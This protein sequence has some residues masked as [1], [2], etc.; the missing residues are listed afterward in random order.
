MSNRVLTAASLLAAFAGSAVAAPEIDALPPNQPLKELREAPRGARIAQQNNSAEQ[1]SL[2]LIYEIAGPTDSGVPGG[3][4]FGSGGSPRT[5]DVG[6]LRAGAGFDVT[7]AVATAFGYGWNTGGSTALPA[8]NFDLVINFFSVPNEG[9]ATSNGSTVAPFYSGQFAS[10]R[11]PDICPDP[12]FVS[13]FPTPIQFLDTNSNVITVT[14]QDSASNP[15]TKFGYEQNYYEVGSSSFFNTRTN[16]FRMGGTLQPRVGTNDFRGWAFG[17]GASGGPGSTP[18]S[19]TATDANTRQLFQREGNGTATNRRDSYLKMWGQLPAP[20]APSVVTDVGTVSCAGGVLPAVTVAFS[21][22]TD[23]M[24]APQGRWFKFTTPVDISSPDL[25]FLDISVD[26]DPGSGIPMQT[27]FG[28]YA[29]NGGRLVADATRGIGAVNPLATFGHG[30]RPGLGGTEQQGRPM[31]RDGRDGAL[32]AGTY[33]LFVTGPEGRYGGASFAVDASESTA[34]GTALLVFDTNA[35][36]TNC[37]LPTPVAPTVTRNLGTLSLGNQATVND[38]LTGVEDVEWYTF[39]TDFDILPSNA[40]FLDIHSIGS[41]LGGNI[42]A[43]Y[44]NSGN[45]VSASYADDDSGGLYLGTNINCA[46]TDTRAQLSFG[47]AAAPRSPLGPGLPFEGQNGDTLAAGTYWLAVGLDNGF[48]LPAGWQVRSDSG[49]YI[50]MWATLR[51]PFQCN[52]DYNRDGFLNL[53][54][55]GDFIT[56]FYT[57][58]AIPGGLQPNAPTYSDN[59]LIGYGIGC[60]FAGPA[61]APYDSE[62]YKQFGFRVGYSSDGSNSCPLDPSQLFPNLDNLNDYITFYYSSFGTPIC[63]G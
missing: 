4:L 27:T 9:T 35:D 45:A 49:S 52:A 41:D 16:G 26:I 42:Y 13:W 6:T 8:A 63:G 32:A 25:N 24:V 1:T 61:P 3:T 51:T 46:P 7:P 38:V 18:W 14:F 40:N 17:V 5:Y 19:P 58:P 2:Q 50:F 12:G 62:A 59:A 55:L 39:T 21:L 23:P 31:D 29:S 36:T 20:A 22:S 56:D 60:T 34:D 30:R 28:M 44:D 53:D 57:D 37:A 10:L 43:L 33:Y 48:V 11:I 54:D 47:G 15:V